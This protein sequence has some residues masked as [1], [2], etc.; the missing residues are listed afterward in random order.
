MPVR[1]LSPELA[2][3]ARVELFEDP[4]KLEDSIQHLR[5]WIAKQPH[6]RARTGTVILKPN[7]TW[8]SVQVISTSQV[9]ARFNTHSSTFTLLNIE[10]A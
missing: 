6:L 2:E 4:K 5:E 3:K 1:P 9:D 10:L 7:R 8:Y